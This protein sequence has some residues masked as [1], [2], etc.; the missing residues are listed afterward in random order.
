[1][2]FSYRTDGTPQPA[3]ERRGFSLPD[4]EGTGCTQ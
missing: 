4:G 2:M 1:M 3:G